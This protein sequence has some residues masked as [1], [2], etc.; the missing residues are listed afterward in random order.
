MTVAHAGKLRERGREGGKGK[1]SEVKPNTSGRS[2][3]DWKK[4]KKNA[5][6]QKE[7]KN[8]RRKRDVELI[9]AVES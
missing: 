1:E 7:G 2:R 4:F 6:S 5:R 8:E 3:K 9:I